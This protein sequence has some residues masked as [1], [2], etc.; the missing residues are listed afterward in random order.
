MRRAAEEQ[1]AQARQDA[2]RDQAG[3][4]AGLEAQIAAAEEA[5]AGLQ[6]RAEQ[7][8]ADTWQARFAARQAE[9]QVAEAREAKAAAEQQA[10]AAQEQ[11]A[12]ARQERDEAVAG[13]QSR[14]AGAE[15][16]AGQAGQD[17]AEPAARMT[18]RLSRSVP[19]PA[20]TRRPGSP[21]GDNPKAQHAAA[22]TPGKGERRRG[23]HSGPRAR[24]ILWRGNRRAIRAAGWRIW[25]AARAPP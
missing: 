18:P 10:R 25:A 13:A 20:V 17:A 11:L 16:R 7:A 5:R 9:A 22:G 15:S 3:L 4:R 8:E 19:A 6:A 14:A 1:V 2:E 23:L 12:A 21:P 24:L